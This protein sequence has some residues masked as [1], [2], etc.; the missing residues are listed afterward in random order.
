MRYEELDSEG[1][2]IIYLKMRDILRRRGRWNPDRREVMI[3][4]AK[5]EEA[6]WTFERDEVIR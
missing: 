6:G 1:Q 4:I 5:C 3:F 2:K